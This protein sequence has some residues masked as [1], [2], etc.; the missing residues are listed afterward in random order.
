MLLRFLPQLL[1]LLLVGSSL[2]ALAQDLPSPAA[3]SINDEAR[4]FYNQVIQNS[5]NPVVV[6]LAR[7]NLQKLR[8]QVMARS[9]EIPLLSQ[10]SGSLAVPIM[11]NHTMATFLVD[12]G[13][14][15]TVLTP[16]MAKKLGIVV[17]PDMERITILTANGVVRVPKVV[18][19]DLSVGGVTVHNVEAII[20][21]LGP[22]P[23]LSG[24]LGLNFF[25][26]VELTVKTDKL[27]LTQTIEG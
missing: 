1:G 22:D 18:I 21:D 5:Q 9:V 24:L 15:H 7:E 14:T 6:Q 11:A 16:R 27:I 8:R 20:Q 23:L 3:N 12:T 25:K 2:P 26:D 4:Q 10:V 13:A 19:A 17:T